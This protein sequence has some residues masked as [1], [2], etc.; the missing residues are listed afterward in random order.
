M[1]PTII[2]AKAGDAQLDTSSKPARLHI[3]GDWTLA[4]YA[5][6]KQLNAQLAGKYDD[7][8]SS[9]AR[10]SAG[11]VSRVAANAQPG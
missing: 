1:E 8:A 7:S 9:T 6:L 11:G 4:N 2:T 5:R 10:D 3:S